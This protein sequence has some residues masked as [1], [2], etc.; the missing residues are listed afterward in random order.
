MAKIQV[1]WDVMQCLRVNNKYSRTQLIRINWDGE[2][3]GNAEI[4]II[5]F[6]FENRLHWRFKVEKIL[7]KPLF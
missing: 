2:P 6:Y 4:R 7:Y 1:F 5:G 3:F